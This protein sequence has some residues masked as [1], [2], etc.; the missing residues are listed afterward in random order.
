MRRSTAFLLAAVLV[1][2]TSH[3]AELP[4]I[5]TMYA[6]PHLVGNQDASE[7]FVQGEALFV[8]EEPVTVGTDPQHDPQRREV[9]LFGM[10]ARNLA[11]WQPSTSEQTLW[12]AMSFWDLQVVAPEAAE[13]RWTFNLGGVPYQ[14]EAFRGGLTAAS[15]SEGA[16]DTMLSSI[17]I[18]DRFRLLG[19]CSTVQGQLRCPYNRPVDGQIDMN[20]DRVIWRVPIELPFEIG[21]VISPHPDGA[22]ATFGTV[23]S[24]PVTQTGSYTTQSMRVLV[25]MRIPG[26]ATV[27]PQRAAFLGA[28]RL[29]GGTPFFTNLLVGHLD[30]GVPGPTTPY[31]IVATACAGQGC[32]PASAVTIKL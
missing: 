10:D 17:P 3:A 22:R 26:G 18:G 19:P 11:I 14:L 12:F 30:R 32:G 28:T 2:S 25:S 4:Q 13:W 31:E 8:G 1:P 9:G 20:S 7:V 23:F 27:L 16:P 15:T 24:D 29:D 6:D 21:S 5:L